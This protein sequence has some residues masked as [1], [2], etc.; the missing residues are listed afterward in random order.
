MPNPPP[1]GASEGRTIAR[2][3]GVVAVFTLLSRILGYVRDTTLGHVFGAGVEHDAYVVAST[4]PNLLRRLVAEGALMIAFIPLLSEEKTKGGLPAMQRFTGAVLGI[5][6][7]VLLLLTGIGMAFPDQ[8]VTLFAA[9]FDGPRAELAADLTR[10]M[11]GF[12][13]FIS[14][15]ALASGVL[16]TQ[17]SFGPPAAAPMLLNL[18]IIVAAVVFRELF[19]VPMHAVAWGFLIGGALQLVLQ[20]PFLAKERMI[21][22]PHLDLKHPALRLLGLRM[23]PA[24]FGVAVYQLNIIIIRQIASFLPEGHLSC[25]FW[26]TRLQEFALGVFAVSISIAALP[27]LSE[28]AA[29]KDVDKLFATF[30]R[31]LR[32]TNFITVPATVLLLVAATPIVGVLYRH[33]EFSSSAGA[34]TAQLVAIMA[35]ALVPIGAVRVMVPT[36]YAI[37][38]TKTPV[39]AATASMITTGAVGWLLKE[40]LG[41]AG[42]T[43]ATVLAAAAQ[44]VVLSILLRRRVRAMLKARRSPGAPKGPSVAGHAMRCLVAVTPGGLLALWASHARPWLGGDNL[45]GAAWLGLLFSVVVLGYFGL[46]K[47]LRLEEGDLILGAVLRRFRR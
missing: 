24:V 14:L 33:G 45:V 47:A 29:N 10:I 8:A 25:Y 28:H 5:L 35:V 19:D 4:I 31:A 1:S 40:P 34:L 39:L 17:G 30:R 22:R 7:P 11:M 37:G 44:V 46:A 21:V 6:L 42:L 20:L 12:L 3:A 2:R 23:L 9:G 36:Y 16:N 27:T 38:D 43:A 15:T 18:A 26:A 41:I 32:A 13:V